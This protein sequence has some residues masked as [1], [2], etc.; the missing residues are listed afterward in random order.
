MKKPVKYKCPFCGDMKTKRQ[1]YAVTTEEG[2]KARA[3]REHFPSLG[4]FRQDIRL[5][6]AREVHSGGS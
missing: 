5:K 1:S 3:C 6:K 2:K 4:K